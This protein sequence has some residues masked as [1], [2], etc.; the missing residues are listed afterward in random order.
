MNNINFLLDKWSIQISEAVIDAHLIY[1]NKEPSLLDW[2]YN[3]DIL[4][5]SINESL[6]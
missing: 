4:K 6:N 3:L 1:G 2:Q 5:T